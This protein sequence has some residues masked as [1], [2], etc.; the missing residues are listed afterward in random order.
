M[1]LAPILLFTYKRLDTLLLTV[2]ALKNND[3]A[4]ASTL[5]IFSDGAK[6]EKDINEVIKVRK[7][8]KSISGFNKILIYESNTNQGLANSIIAG[9]SEVIKV[10]KKVIVVE[11]DL[12]TSTN[13]LSFM[14][15][16]LNFYIKK[17]NVFSISGYSPPILNPNNDIYFTK[18]ASSWGWATW[19]DRWSQIDWDVTSYC[20]F[21]NNIFQRR[22]FN[23][24]GSD[25]SRM[26]DKQIKGKINSW[27]IRWVYHQFINNLYT[28]YPTT[29]K[30]INIGTGLDATHTKD[31]FNRFYT[32]LDNSNKIYFDFEHDVKINKIYL[33]QFLKQ[34][35]IYTRIKYKLLNLFN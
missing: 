30:I 28:V 29:S 10:H 1:E 16:A 26:L 21:K 4:S 25:L 34:F 2:N 7:Y 23:T 27:A 12:I 31:S 24:M 8:L 6:S 13:F 20:S 18:R 11:D 35:S 14:N 3:Y 15:N 33:K 22:K 9:V 32:R 19:N 5:Y 17:T